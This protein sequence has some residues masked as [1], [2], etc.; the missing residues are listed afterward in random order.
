MRLQFLSFFGQQELKHR[1]RS[2]II[3]AA[4]SA[5]ALALSGSSRSFGQR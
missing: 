3:D 2:Y 4:C 1:I 5:A